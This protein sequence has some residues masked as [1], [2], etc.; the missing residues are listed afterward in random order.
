[1]DARA[2]DPGPLAAVECHADGARWTLV[3]VRD[4]AHPRE[5]VWAALTDPAQ[6][7]A[8][9]PYTSDRD[10]G[11]TGPA[12][13][14]MSDGSTSEVAPATV[15]V[16]DAPALLEYTW[17]DDVLQW[18]LDSRG[19]GT[20]LT[21]RHTVER[22]EWVPRVAAGWHLCLVVADR[23]LAGDP[24]PRIVGEQARDYGW[25]RLHDEYGAQLGITGTGWPEGAFPRE[26]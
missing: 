18:R 5:K 2:F 6:L 11:R 7:G 4:F 22:H 8:W 13:L 21:L 10:L 9:A 19:G 25:E 23:M 14:T 16:A 12:T 15:R 3:F 26:D 24:I 17:G 20:R 1:M